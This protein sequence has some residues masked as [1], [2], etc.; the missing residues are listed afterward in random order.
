MINEFPKR[1]RMR[2]KEYD[3]S[4][5]AYYFITICM[6]DRKSFLSKIVSD[7]SILT[8]Y[9]KIVNEIWNNLPKYYPCEIDEFIIMPEHF[10]SIIILNNKSSSDIK[11]SLSS[12]IQRFKTF[13]TKKINTLLQNNEKFYWQKSFYDRIIRNERELYEIRKYIRMN[14]LYWEIEKDLPENLDL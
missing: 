13:S 8:K 9:G 4:N 6:K 5:N 14:P 12:I 11:K 2:L 3:Y 10:H 7:K 1:K